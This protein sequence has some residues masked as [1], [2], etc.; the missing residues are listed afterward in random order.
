MLIMHLQVQT[1]VVL[2]E[3]LVENVLHVG[4]SEHRVHGVL[5]AGGLQAVATQ[6][7]VWRKWPPF[8]L[9]HGD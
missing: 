7:L 3:V 9:Q 2:L 4:L 5:S 1:L 6:T 8:L